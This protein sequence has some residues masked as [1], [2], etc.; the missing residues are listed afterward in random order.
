MSA[1][2]L[3]PA[4][5]NL[6]EEIL[7]LLA[8]AGRDFSRNIVLFPGKRPGHVLRKALAERS[9]GSIIPPKIFSMDTFV[10]F[11]FTEKLHM[12]MRPIE[13]VD[14][15]ALLYEIHLEDAHRLGGGHFVTLDSF[16][17]LGLKIFQE[18]EELS[19]AG[20]PVRSVREALSGFSYGELTSLTIFYERLYNQAAKKNLATKAMRYR[21]V[22]E[23]ISSVDLTDVT[24]LIVAGFFG[25]TNCEKNIFKHFN[26]LENVRQIFHNGIGIGRQLGELG[27]SVE[28]PP[29]PVKRP[30]LFFYR[31]A[32]G[33][34]QVFGLSRKVE[35]LTKRGETAIAKSVVV[36]PAADTLFP[37]YHQALTLL[38]E[39]QFNISMGY[40]VTRTPVYGFLG[41]LLDLIVSK[42]ESR[43]SSS[44]YIKFILH[45]YTKNIRFGQRADVT[46]ILFN[47]IEEIFLKESTPMF[48]SLEELEAHPT[49]FEHT[50]KRVAG[51][52]ESIA[53]DALKDHLRSIHEKTIR[54]FDG[55][56][57]IASFAGTSIEVLRYISAHSTAQL[58]PFFRPFAETLI[59]TLETISSSLL[60]EKRF[61]EFVSYVS[62]LRSTIAETK[63]PFT[64]TPL[65]GLQ[66]LGFLET[67][68][69]HF[70]TVFILDANDDV[71][72]GNKGHDVLLP[73]KFREALGLPTYRE[74][75]RE[76]EYY[77][78]LLLQGAKEVHLFFVEDGRKEKSRFIE[79]L[80]WEKQ[81]KEKKIE[82]NEYVET[83]R[84]RVQLANS[85]PKPISKT[86]KI[87]DFLKDFSFNATALDTYLKC[88]LK[89]YYSQ[90]LHLKEREEVS[91]ELA[92][93][94][95]GS[96]VHRV[97]AEYFG[98]F[99]R[100][101]LTKDLLNISDFE[102]IL[103]K[104]FME[105]FGDRPIGAHYLL[106]A[107]IRNHL[108]DFINRYQVPLL[109][110]GITILDVERT[111]QASIGRY[112]VSGKLD[113]VEKR[114]GEIY[115]L[116][117]KTGGSSKRTSINFK[118]LAI[119]DRESWSEAI[120]SLQLPLYAMIYAAATG[121]GREEIQPAYLFLGKQEI[122]GGIE[123]PLFDDSGG[124][125]DKFEML[126]KIIVG[127]LD[128]ITSTEHAFQP[129][130]DFDHNCPGCEFKYICGTQ[131]V[132]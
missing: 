23:R 46:R 124:A 60:R 94:D 4:D 130:K 10:D 27:L 37:M 53:A 54:A 79:K 61:S 24:A 91:G 115:I 109:D 32:D 123:E 68:S 55:V 129:T 64:G 41:T 69:L 63:V 98:T 56:D 49:L 17:P 66:V 26:S 114:D 31:S 126:E 76:A 71:L 15:V 58:H 113:R 102:Q 112:N 96:F 12:A 70:D 118:K 47:T 7:P 88:Q 28:V 35:E 97:L 44:Q 89:F 83:L 74:R 18:L 50:A 36:L 5:R 92:K 38:P 62:F 101:K 13:P 11:V 14:A 51:T 87:V 19:M 25:F 65:Q 48:F 119:D 127:L 52:G 121:V 3:I 111:M 43:Y 20:L 57:S 116:D 21:A 73:R 108:N 30:A 128:E 45:P 131:W 110:K 80:L 93:A 16:L 107:Q 117:Y 72:P 67:H 122:N 82:A 77:F 22:A 40:P 78:D 34:G 8:G 59:E 99:I 6:I 120:G 33:H 29:E 86:K 75:E 85:T 84:Y 106:R 90:V 95:I 39:D 1:V 2:T 9:G 125:K 103:D 42:Y 104:L 100:K 132:S 105:E 81:Q